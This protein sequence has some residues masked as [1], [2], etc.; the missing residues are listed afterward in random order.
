MPFPVCVTR[1]HGKPRVK[2]ELQ[3]HW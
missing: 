2:T 3:R 1:F